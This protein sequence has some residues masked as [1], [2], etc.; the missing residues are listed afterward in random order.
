MY[1][2]SRTFQSAI[3]IRSS[4]KI[5]LSDWKTIELFVLRQNDFL[6]FDKKSFFGMFNPL[7]SK[8]T[9]PR[10]TGTPPVS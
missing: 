8:Q 1:S 9:P 3:F 2:H 4:R 10:R 5:F 7:P 6:F